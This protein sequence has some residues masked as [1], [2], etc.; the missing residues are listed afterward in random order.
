MLI[1]FFPYFHLYLKFIYEPILDR[2]DQVNLKSVDFQNHGTKKKQIIFVS[3]FYTD[4]L[5]RVF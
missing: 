3:I 1:E 4:V 5:N 2:P